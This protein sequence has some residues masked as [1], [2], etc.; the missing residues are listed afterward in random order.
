MLYYLS[1]RSNFKDKYL[2][3]LRTQLWRC[4]QKSSRSWLSSIFI[5]VLHRTFSICLCDLFLPLFLKPRTQPFQS[6]WIKS[7]SEF[8]LMIYSRPRKVDSFFLLLL[9]ISTFILFGVWMVIRTNKQSP[10]K[11]DTPIDIY[12]FFLWCRISLCEIRLVAGDASSQLSVNSSWIRCL[13][14]LFNSPGQLDVHCLHL[15]TFHVI[16]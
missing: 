16:F 13:P 8:A 6:T 1:P 5:I 12:I 7:W 2:L 15:P 4:F 11:L 14:V 10:S 9:W 3:E